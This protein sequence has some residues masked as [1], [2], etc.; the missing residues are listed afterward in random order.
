M[1]AQ[2]PNN[3]PNNE[4]IFEG[5]NKAGIATIQMTTTPPKKKKLNNK[6]LIIDNFS[7]FSL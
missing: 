1:T 2:Y 4:V 6:D 3:F 7:I 5:S